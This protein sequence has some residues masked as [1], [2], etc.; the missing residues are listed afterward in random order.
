LKKE[1]LSDYFTWV[2]AVWL[3]SRGE[4]L[5]FSDRKYL[6][7]VYTDQHPNIVYTKSSQMGLSERGISESVWLAEQKN[8]NTL[9]TFPAQKQ[10]QEFVQARVNPVLAS[11]DYLASRVGNVKGKSVETL[12]L[13]RI[14]DA[15]I[16]FRGSQNEKQIITIDADMIVIDERD[17]FNEK[18]VPFI[19]KRLLASSL[20]W[21]REIST[22]TIPETGVHKSFLA[23]DMRV[24]EIPCQN[25]KCRHWQ[26]L[27]FFKN[28]DKK[29]KVVRCVKCKA[30]M[31]RFVDGRWRPLKPGREVHGYRINGMYNPSVTIPEMWKK[32]KKA[33]KSGA[34]ALQQFYNQ[35]LGFPFD[36]VGQKVQV[37]ELNSCKRGYGVPVD[38]KKNKEVYVGADVGVKYIHAVVLDK[39]EDDRSRLIWAGTVKD[40]FGPRDSLEAI[41]S[42][43]KVKRLVIDQRPEVKKVKEFMDYFPGKVYAADYPNSKFSVQEYVRWD[44]IKFEVKL[45][46]TISLDYLVSDIQNQRIELPENIESI[47]DFYYQLRSASRVMKKNNQGV[48]VAGWVEKGPDH[49]FHAL[50]Y[51]RVS[52][53]RGIEGKALLDYYR[54]PEKGLTPSFV[55]WL[56]INA[57]RI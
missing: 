55:N 17:R 18:N 37:S 51:A 26:E 27:N 9:Y 31:N 57:Q 25:K 45:D 35:D 1:K 22:P 32:Y 36:V 30:L 53:S 43:Y 2:R 7:Q 49:Y 42:K 19:E 39:L 6:V 52:Q 14:G 28:I 24:W 56:R 41:M 12:G 38:V 16:Y 5:K 44:D 10:L 33:A 23:T 47:E 4:P 11:S 20:K 50:N 54:E 29:K 13:K 21:R 34:S 46:R 3:T 48:E 15:Y 40:F 8:L